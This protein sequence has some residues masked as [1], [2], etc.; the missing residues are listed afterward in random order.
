MTFRVVGF[1]PQQALRRL[2]A[3]AIVAENVASDVHLPSPS[4]GPPPPS[5]SADQG[6]LDPESPAAP[7]QENESPIP[8]ESSPSSEVEEDTKVVGGSGTP[9][10]DEE[11]GGLL[12]VEGEG[13]SES[14]EEDHGAE[15][16]EEG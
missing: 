15:G 14:V 2:L 11:Q 13:T 10:A 6:V 9:D 8:H 3:K 1:R 12:G 4:P 16:S 5:P 7:F